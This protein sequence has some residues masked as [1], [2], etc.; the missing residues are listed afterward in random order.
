MTALKEHVGDVSPRPYAGLCCV[1]LLTWQSKGHCW[2]NSLLLPGVDV[3]SRVLIRNLASAC[4]V[5]FSFEIFPVV[6][7]AQARFTESKH[8]LILEDSAGFACES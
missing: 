4:F 6:I 8:A 2:G 7:L 3:Y 1:I 5:S